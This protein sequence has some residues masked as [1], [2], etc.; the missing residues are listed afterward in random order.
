MYQKITLSQVNYVEG[1]LQDYST[2]DIPEPYI[3]GGPSAPLMLGGQ[4]VL[5]ASCR[6][7][8]AS[9]DILEV[10]GRRLG[11]SWDI[12]ETSWGILEASWRCLG[13]TLG[14]LEG[15]LGHLGGILGARARV[16]ASVD[17]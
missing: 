17:A 5:E 11:A 16:V 12:L 7:L 15:I 13:S 1:S 9:W 14:R 4:A 6:I 8:E 3:M 2:R 10:S